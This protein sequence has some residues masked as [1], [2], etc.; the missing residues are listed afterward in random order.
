MRLGEFL[1]M[2]R[3]FVRSRARALLKNIDLSR[4]TYSDFEKFYVY[5]TRV[6]AL[7]LTHRYLEGENK[8]LLSLAQTK[9]NF[10]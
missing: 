9:N 1:Y 3:T 7:L 4:R 5:L 10:E 8:E 6:L 2:D